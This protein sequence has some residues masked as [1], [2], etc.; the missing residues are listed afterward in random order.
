MFSATTT[1]LSLGAEPS[2]LWLET[3]PKGRIR[4]GTTPIPRVGCGKAKRGCAS[5]F[6]LPPGVT[7]RRTRGVLVERATPPFSPLVRHAGEQRCRQRC[8]PFARLCGGVALSTVIPGGKARN[9]EDLDPGCPV[10]PGLD[11]RWT[12][13]L[14]FRQDNA[15]CRKRPLEYGAFYLSNKSGAVNPLLVPILTIKSLPAQVSRI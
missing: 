14:R 1:L 8:R 2:P 3:S 6:P 10:Q 15:L 11:G 5:R 7:A 9:A 12:S 13:S 4:C